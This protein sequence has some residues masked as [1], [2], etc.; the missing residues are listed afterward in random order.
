PHSELNEHEPQRKSVILASATRIQQLQLQV[1]AHRETY[2]QHI[3][4]HNHVHRTNPF[5]KNALE[6]FR[7]DACSVCY[8][9]TQQTSPAFENYRLLIYRYDGRVSQITY[10]R[11][12]EWQGSPRK[13][14]AALRL[15]KATVFPYAPLRVASLVEALVNPSATGRIYLADFSVSEPISR[16]RTQELQ[17]QVAEYLQVTEAENRKGKARERNPTS[18]GSI[19][20]TSNYRTPDLGPLY[21]PDNEEKEKELSLLGSIGTIELQDINENSEDEYDPLPNREIPDEIFGHRE[22]E[23]DQDIPENERIIP[24]NPADNNL[25]QDSDQEEPEQQEENQIENQDPPANQGNHQESDQETL[26]ENQVEDQN[27]GNPPNNPDSSGEESEESSQA[28]SRVA[29][30]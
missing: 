27:Q 11:F 2:W 3:Y 24:E 12:V 25:N 30:P 4:I 20:T 19:A 5:K 9:I 23:N 16:T 26:E 7:S 8:Q 13:F 22:F 6:E 15:I 17:N 28:S 29:S 1:E 10:D 21:Q 14:Q 18:P